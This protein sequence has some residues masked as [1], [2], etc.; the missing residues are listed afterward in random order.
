MRNAE[1]IYRALII[2]LLLIITSNTSSIIYSKPVEITLLYDGGIPNIYQIFITH[3][4]PE[5]GYAVKFVPDSQVFRLTSILVYGCYSYSKSSTH[6]RMF[7][8]EIRDNR[9]KLLK[10]LQYKYSKFFE[11]YYYPDS[12]DEIPSGYAKWISISINYTVKTSPFYVIFFTNSKD[13]KD[14]LWIGTD[15]YQDILGREQ[16]PRVTNSYYY[17]KGYGLL[18][19]K[20]RPEHNFLIRSCG[21]LLYPIK[22][23]IN[24]LPPN[25]SISMKNETHVFSVKVGKIITFYAYNGSELSIL[26]DCIYISENTRYICENPKQI[27]KDSGTITFTFYPEYRVSISVEP[28]SFFKHASIKIND[29]DYKNQFNGWF[30]KGE[31]IQISVPPQVT[32]ISTKYIFKHWNIGKENPSIKLIVNSPLNICAHYKV[33]YY[34]NVSSPYG[35]VEG[36]GW[37]DRGTKA[38]IRLDKTIVYSEENIRHVFSKW[39]PLGVTNPVFQI[40]IERPMTIKAEWITQYKIEIFSPYGEVKISNEW[41]SENEEVVVEV[42]PQSIGFIIR[43][44]FSHWVDQDNNEYKEARVYIKVNKPIKLRAIWIDDYTNL[45]LLIISVLAFGVLV[46]Y[47]KK[48]SNRR[49]KI[50]ALQY[51]PCLLYTSPSPR[52]RG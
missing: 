39:T 14:A 47:L 36:A 38:I 16:G 10:R 2:L 25:Y 19:N 27:I 22:V 17:F 46:I 29:L 13:E 48:K 33:Q 1:L 23:N 40:S 31:S 5:I 12:P 42:H 6:D 28:E 32:N 18:L 21:Y 30:K 9:L 44:I 15:G 45:F 34:V 49:R 50:K 20:A 52:D 4:R 24:G 37:Y 8:I 26:D 43:K 7:Y 11:G 3:K 35:T 41:V 51:I